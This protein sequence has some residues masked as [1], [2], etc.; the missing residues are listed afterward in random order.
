[1]LEGGSLH[2]V[3]LWLMIA[4]CAMPGAVNAETVRRGLRFGFESA[5]LVQLGA[6][7]GRVVWAGLALTGTRVLTDPGLLHVSLAALGA[8]VLLRA[9]WQTLA[10]SNIGSHTS[11]STCHV[12]HSAFTAGLLLSLTNPL[13][14]VF[15]SGLVSFLG[16]GGGENWDAPTAPSVLAALAVGALAWSVCAAAAISWGRCAVGRGSLRRAEVLT[17]MILGFFG[18]HML[19]ETTSVLVAMAS[20]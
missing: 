15:W 3:A 20:R 18:L 16:L 13:A 12:R 8:V 4:Y 1:M 14:L 5:L 6:V 10:A 2:V 17:A 7:A 11:P 9:S 19:L